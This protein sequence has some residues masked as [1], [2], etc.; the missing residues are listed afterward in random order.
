MTSETGGECCLCSGKRNTQVKQFPPHGALFTC[1]VCGTY[2]AA[3]KFIESI[4]LG[5]IGHEIRA[6]LSAAVRD[7]KESPK[8]ATGT[9]LSL[10]LENYESFAGKHRSTVPEKID[11]LLLLLARLSQFP[12]NE[13]RLNLEIDYPLVDARSPGELLA[14]IEYLR[15][16]G[17]LTLQINSSGADCELTI[18]GWQ[19]AQPT[20]RADVIPNRC[21]VIMW[22]DP[23][24]DAPYFEG[25][26]PAI[27][28][29]GFEPRRMKEIEFN[30]GITDRILAEIR[31]ARFVVA[32]FTGV[33]PN[34]Y[35]EAGFAK[36]LGREV[37]WCCK[38]SEAGE[39]HFDTKHLN[40]IMWV[41]IPDLKQ[42]L[43]DRIRAT[44][45]VPAA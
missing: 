32:D 24:M 6:Q 14:Y 31:Q 12:G 45:I 39:L 5:S 29:C 41:D 26:E 18:P 9:H 13:V 27:R 3:S 36:G 40:H 42:R 17:L 38:Q 21:F 4:E 22:F 43:T 34:V 44:V 35:F 2:F 20:L 10:T 11:K 8:L 25:I 37:I 1:E 28:E 33:R 19:K 15:D 7:E 30:E 16:S 23:S